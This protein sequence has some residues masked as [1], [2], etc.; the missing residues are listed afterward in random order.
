MAEG[1]AS[2][3]M[4]IAGAFMGLLHGDVGAVVRGAAVLFPKDSPIRNGLT[5]TGALLR[6]DVVTAVR[7]AAK[8][9]PRGTAIGD[10]LATAEGL[11]STA[12]GIAGMVKR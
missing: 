5:A 8:M 11:I 4:A 9:V 10:A 6:G 7:S 2:D 12:Q 1:D 3:A